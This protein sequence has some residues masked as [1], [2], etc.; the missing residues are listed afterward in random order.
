MLLERNAIYINGVIGVTT[1]RAQ[2]T[3]R[4]PQQSLNHCTLLQ[5]GVPD[6]AAT[7]VARGRPLLPVPAS[8]RACFSMTEPDRPAAVNSTID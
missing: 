5:A 2:P 1:Q 8:A 3:R 4:L 7:C 6:Q